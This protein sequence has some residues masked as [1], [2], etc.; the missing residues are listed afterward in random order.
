MKAQ[1]E[2]KAILFTHEKTKVW[3]AGKLHVTKQKLDYWLNDAKSMDVD[4]Y[5]QIM[6]IFKHEKMICS[7]DDKCDHIRTQT[8][9]INSIIGS[10]LTMLNS[11][12]KTVSSDNIL[13]FKEKK[14][15]SEMIA[16]LRDNLNHEL[17][18]IAEM[19]EK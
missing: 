19:I 9:E 3:L 2:I 18:K 1:D 16:E 7:A 10:S 17:D 13:D 12:V 6:S 5:N 8:M 14:L 11:T 4:T 15:L